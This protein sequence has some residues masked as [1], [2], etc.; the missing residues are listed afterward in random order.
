MMVGTFR[1][2]FTDID[3]TLTDGKLVGK[4]KVGLTADQG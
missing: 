2:E 1:G 4:V 3:A